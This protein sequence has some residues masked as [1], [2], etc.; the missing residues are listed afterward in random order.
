VRPGQIGYR[1]QLAYP[2]KVYLPAHKLPLGAPIRGRYGV[3]IGI[4]DRFSG[5]RI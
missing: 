5:R 3:P 4:I 1:A 2:K